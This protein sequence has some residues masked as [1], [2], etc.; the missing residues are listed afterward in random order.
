MQSTESTKDIKTEEIMKMTL[1]LGKINMSYDE[2]RKSKKN[3]FIKKILGS[4][5][6]I[7]G[8]SILFGVFSAYCGTIGQNASGIITTISIALSTF[9][10]LRAYALATNIL[11]A[12][13]FQKVK[14]IIDACVVK[15]SENII[16]VVEA[17]DHKEMDEAK[18]KISITRGLCITKLEKKHKDRKAF[19]IAMGALA[20]V[21]FGGMSFLNGIFI[22]LLGVSLIGCSYLYHKTKK[23][24]T[25]IQNLH[26]R[27]IRE[28]CICK[29]LKISNEDNSITGRYLYFSGN[30]P[31]YHINFGYEGMICQQFLE[32]QLYSSVQEGDFCYLLFIDGENKIDLVFPE[33][34][35][36]IDENEFQR[37]MVGFEPK[38]DKTVDEIKEEWNAAITIQLDSEELEAVKKFNEVMEKANKKANNLMIVTGLGLFLTSCSIFSNVVWLLTILGEMVVFPIYQIIALVACYK[39]R[40]ACDELVGT[41]AYSEMS[42]KQNKIV[43]KILGLL[44]GGIFLWLGT[45]LLGALLSQ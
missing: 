4:T 41:R 19:S 44:F 18:A 36:S 40:V 11:N 45:L 8:V 7:C 20:I 29:E 32:E 5:F 17:D 15:P 23:R 3:P 27:I 10:S 21:I 37:N 42:D 1:L 26:F 24:L 33:K 13:R 35:Y 2:V 9:I 31:R 14:K 28:Q 43:L 30:T 38:C 16:G 25:N 12:V 6:I 39:T 22:V 34:E